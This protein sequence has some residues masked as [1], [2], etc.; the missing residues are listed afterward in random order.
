[1]CVLSNKLC[2]C[3][4]AYKLS[5]KM[6]HGTATKS[7]NRSDVPAVIFSDQFSKQNKKCSTEMSTFGVL[8]VCVCV[9]VDIWGWEQAVCWQSSSSSIGRFSEAGLLE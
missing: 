7:R 6:V 2:L 5:I 1:M 3:I 8:C 9:F 4:F